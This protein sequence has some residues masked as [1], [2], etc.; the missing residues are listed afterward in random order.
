VDPVD[1]KCIIAAMERVVVRVLDMR[2]E[3][4]RLDAAMGDGDTGITVAK[5][6]VALRGFLAT[7]PPTEDLGRFFSACGKAINNAA[8]STLGTL[9]AM[10]L[11]RGGKELGGLSSLDLP[12]L[13]KFL[14][15]ADLG[16][17]EFGKAKPGDKT[18]V[19]ALHPAA[20]TFC[21]AVKEGEGPERASKAM[22]EAARAGRDSAI[23][24]R[25]RIGRSAWVGERTQDKLDP[26][27]V[28]LVSILEAILES[29]GG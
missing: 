12:A 11:M 23:P 28:L 5:G 19:D 25:S 9:A 2:E 16:V 26:G 15:A 8:P 7:N 1:G 3:L 4:N 22:L 29:D 18:V 21:R 13:A 6:A 10:A 14:V 24:L 20:E 17:Q 27:T